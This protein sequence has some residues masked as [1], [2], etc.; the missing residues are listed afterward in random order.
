[1]VRPPEAIYI[2]VEL[3]RHNP[4]FLDPQHAVHAVGEIE[5]MGGDRAPAGSVR[6][7]FKSASK[8]LSAVAGSR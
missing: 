8:T 4:L 1:M 5:I 3:D 6:G 2:P 7:I